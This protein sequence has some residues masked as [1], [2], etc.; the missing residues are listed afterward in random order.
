MKNEIFIGT[1][2]W[3]HKG[4]HKKFYPEKE[5]EFLKYYA[6]HFKTVEINNSFYHLPLKST[7]KKWYGEVGPDFI[8]SVKLSRYITHIERLSGVKSSCE[9]FLRRSSALKEKHGPILVQLPPFFPC[10]LE[11]LKKFFKGVNEVAKKLNMEIR[12]AFEPR[13]ESWF[14]EENIGE[15]L[16]ILEEN[17]ATPV[18]AHSSKYP[19]FDPDKTKI[20][21][22]VYIRL[23][24]P[25]KFSSSEYRAELLK[26]WASRII[27]WSQ[28]YDVYLYF[29]NDVHGYAIDDSKTLLDLIKTHEEI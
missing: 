27:S 2:G 3:T 13:H 1:S 9:R 20:S 17:N 14:S 10:K 6:G 19:S 8:F 28:K 25:V 15:V 26:P 16:K 12:W 7:Y 29:N 24:G 21:N 18:F 4:W 11:R 22:F 5:K 23:H